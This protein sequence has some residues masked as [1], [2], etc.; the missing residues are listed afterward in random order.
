MNLAARVTVIE[1][2]VT[3][4][5]ASRGERV[6]TALKLARQRSQQGEVAPTLHDVDALE[7][8]ARGTGVTAAM[9]KANL[10]MIRGFPSG[11][12]HTAT[13]ATKDALG[14]EEGGNPAVPVVTAPTG[15]TVPSTATSVSGALVD[16]IDQLLARHA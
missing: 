15:S 3:R 4:L 5:V 16:H 13:V 1:Q 12:L 7:R 8:Q 6:S 11:A 2:V 10:R 14:Y 9:A